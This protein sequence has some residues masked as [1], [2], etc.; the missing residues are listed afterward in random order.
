MTNSAEAPLVLVEKSGGIATVTLNRP[1]AMNALSSGLRAAIADTFEALEADDDVKAVVLTGAG[2]AFC[3][4]LDLKELGSGASTVGGT[5]SDKDPVTSINRFSG[6]VIGAINGV[7]ITGGFELALACDVLICSTNAQ[8]RP[9][10]G[11]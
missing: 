4:G 1:T 7:A 6:P 2:K 3:A 11:A 9:M 5:I 8:S 10:N